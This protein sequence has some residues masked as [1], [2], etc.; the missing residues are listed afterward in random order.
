MCPLPWQSMFEEERKKRERLRDKMA[1]KLAR[2]DQELL[3]TAKQ[4]EAAQAELARLTGAVAAGAP[5]MDRLRNEVG[6]LLQCAICSVVEIY[7]DVCKWLL[8]TGGD[9]SM[10]WQMLA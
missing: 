5:D 1:A 2:R 4:L 9:A 10:Q 7:L 8:V 6:V 3:S